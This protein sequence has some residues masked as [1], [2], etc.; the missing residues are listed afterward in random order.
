MS[1]GKR[2][3]ASHCKINFELSHFVVA[4]TGE[5]HRKRFLNR[6]VLTV[7]TDVRFLWRKLLEKN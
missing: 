4:E 6:G 5:L 2:M 7:L 1:F 3:S